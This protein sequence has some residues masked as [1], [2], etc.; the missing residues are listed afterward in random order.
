[1]SLDQG[2]LI[3]DFEV[4][5]G[6]NVVS[7]PSGDIRIEPKSMNVLMALAE[8]DGETVS[9]LE[10]VESVWPSRFVSED[11]LTRCVAQ[12]RKAFGDKSRSSEFVITI[13]KR[14]YKLGKP[15]RP[16]GVG[17][18]DGFADTPGVLVLPFQ[19]LSASS[20]DSFIADGLTELITASLASHG[21]F[22]V[23][24]RTTAMTFKDANQ[25]LP[26]IARSVKADWVIEG[27]VM[28]LAGSVQ[29]IM[30][31]VSAVDDAH[32]LA[33]TY[34][35]AIEDLLDL[36]REIASTAAAGIS[37]S[38]GIQAPLSGKSVGQLPEGALREYLKGR[39]LQRQRTI[40]ALRTASD[41]F[42]EVL[43]QADYYADAYA[44]LAE[45][46]LLLAHY[47]AEPV[48]QMRPKIERDLEHALSLD[49]NNAIALYCRGATSLF[50]DRDF[51][52]A[53]K[54]LYRT[55]AV[56]PSHSMAAL[57][58][59][60]LSAARRDADGALAWLGHALAVNPLDTGLNM[61]LGDH[62]LLRSE[63]AEA[64]D[65]FRKTLV[66]DPTHTPSRLRLAWSVALEE[67][68]DDAL[69][70]LARVLDESGRTPAFLE[71]SAMIYKAAH[72]DDKALSAFEDL[73]QV[74]R[75]QFIA[76][77]A[78]A[79]AA[80]AAGQKEDAFN[81]LEA[82]VE[83]GSTSLMFF[84]ITPAFE[85]LRDTPRGRELSRRI[86]KDA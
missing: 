56:Q 74:S 11:V 79:R 19:N 84:E 21:N 33:E 82:A 36:H 3:E 24:S 43:R 30:Q 40:G 80:A 16:L 64:S 67:E 68:S 44:S 10:L 60:N 77:W 52:E 46:R 18:R 83:Q 50:F 54:Y 42:S 14:G 63:F 28:I 15:V 51:P 4:R 34:R 32:V 70:E 27:S 86:F 12:I 5:P 26:E 25:P 9:R 66:M 41:C 2:F 35:G 69:A 31:L 29:V 78:L 65:Q 6:D 61:N 8:A 17:N 58:M 13:H 81:F 75:Q 48:M 37:K 53:D 38:M 39:T 57:C 55:L 72:Q 59:A 73:R 23:I 47:G 22:R 20:E 62:L 1:M 49:K 85:S 76:P 7:G 71:Y 45:T